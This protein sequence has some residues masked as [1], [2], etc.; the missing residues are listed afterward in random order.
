[1]NSCHQSLACCSMLIRLICMQLYEIQVVFSR[2]KAVG[3]H[4]VCEPC[5]DE[6]VDILSLLGCGHLSC[7]NGPHW[8]IRNDHIVPVCVQH[9]M[10]SRVMSCQA[11]CL[12]ACQC[13]KNYASRTAHQELRHMLAAS[14]HGS[15]S[16]ACMC[17]H[18]GVYLQCCPQWQSTA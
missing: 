16:S 12:C 13:I 15:H 5:P 7:P 11:T 8:F 10:W 14:C 18:C 9:V 17:S 1:M 3:D 4:L 6:F 2:H